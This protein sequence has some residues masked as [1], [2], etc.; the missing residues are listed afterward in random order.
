MMGGSA[1]EGAG[2]EAEEGA[3]EGE[4]CKGCT[5]GGRGF[6]WGWGLE[7]GKSGGEGWRARVARWADGDFLGEVRGLGGGF[8][9]GAGWKEGVLLVAA[10]G[11]MQK[12][13]VFCSELLGRLVPRKGSYMSIRVMTVPV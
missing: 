2:W 3:W 5:P 8:L 1:L 12:D 13:S 11:R 9:A 7:A 10:C 4:A 6:F